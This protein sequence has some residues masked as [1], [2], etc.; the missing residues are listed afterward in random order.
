MLTVSSLAVGPG[1]DIFVTMSSIRCRDGD[2]LSSLQV[3][4]SLP[5][6]ASARLDFMRIF[7]ARS[8]ARSVLALALVSG[9]AVRISTAR[10]NFPFSTW[11]L[12]ADS[13]APG[14]P[15]CSGGFDVA[16]VATVATSGGTTGLACATAGVET[17]WLAR[18]DGGGGISLGTASLG[19]ASGGG[20]GCGGAGFC[21]VTAITG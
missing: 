19:T 1:N 13:K 5:A 8:R 9:A 6:A 10:S 21:N 18:D 17:A 20:G 2:R 4:G 14:N 7:K 16:G 12:D 3:L 11:I 15:L